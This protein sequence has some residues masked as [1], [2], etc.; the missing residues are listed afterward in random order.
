M[1]EYD[2]KHW[3]H[4]VDIT[5]GQFFDYVKKNIPSERYFIYARIVMSAGTFCGRVIIYLRQARPDPGGSQSI[6]EQ[7]ISL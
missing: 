4:R 2:P 6:P 1:N 5:V 7:G 3:K